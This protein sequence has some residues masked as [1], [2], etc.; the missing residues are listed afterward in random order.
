MAWGI[1]H[2]DEVPR[3]I[4]V[5]NGSPH[6][7][8]IYVTGPDDR[9]IYDLIYTLCEDG[10]WCD[11]SELNAETLARFNE[12]TVGDLSLIHISEPTRP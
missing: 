3:Q 6:I 2:L 9:R 8:T 4:H 7:A 1:K 11:V 5:V 10:R 12:G